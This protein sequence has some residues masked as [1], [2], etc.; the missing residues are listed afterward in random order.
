MA[1]GLLLA[2]LWRGSWLVFK[3]MKLRKRL[4]RIPEAGLVIFAKHAIPLLP[5]R[6]VMALARFFGGAAYH[7]S[8]KLRR[9]AAANLDVAFGDSLSDAKKL[10]INRHSFNN[11]SMLLLDLFWFNKNTKERLDK[12]L[13]FDASFDAVF[14]IPSAIIITAHIGNWEMLAVGCGH[15]GYPLTSIAMPIKNR[16]VNRELL[17]LRT[18]TGS[19]IV[20]RNGGLRDIIKAFKKGRGSELVMDQN[21][22]PEEGGIF[23]PFFGLPAPVSNIAGTLLTRSKSKIV[24]AWCVPDNA[25][26]YT[27]YAGIPYP[28]DDAGDISHED[29]TAQM[30]RELETVIRENPKFWLWS[31]KRWRFYRENDDYSKYPFYAE[32]YEGYARYLALVKKYESAK[33]MRKLKQ[34]RGVERWG[35]SGEKC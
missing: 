21:T 3:A 35:K 25:G 20:S 2:V 16:F 19:E 6:A 26:V 9:I 5:R 29:I 4:R 34:R 22:L 15:Q 24:T 30:T 13:K 10:R 28:A 32:S 7:L 33:A 8:P 31:Y 18:C 17:A 12:Y 14:K 11:F 1:K 27:A 23:V